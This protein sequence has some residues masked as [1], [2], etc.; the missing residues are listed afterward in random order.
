MTLAADAIGIP[1]TTVEGLDNNGELDAIQKAFIE[2][3]AMQCGFCTS[4]MVVSS[5]ALLI[6]NSNPTEED[7]LEAVSGNLCRCGTYPHVVKAIQE[8]ASAKIK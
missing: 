6:R 3:D 5:K 4:G 1:V 7:I 8:T 2:N